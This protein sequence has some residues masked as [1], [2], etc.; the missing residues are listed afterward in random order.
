MYENMHNGEEEVTSG[1]STISSS[2]EEVYR[3]ATKN[4]LTS[5]AAQTASLKVAKNGSNQ[6]LVPGLISS[7]DAKQNAVN[8][9]EKRGQSKTAGESSKK[10]AQT[11]AERE[12]NSNSQQNVVIID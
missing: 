7:H 6:N 12:K 10:N 5:A 3:N 11:G 9:E 4:Q 8:K 1:Y 2:M